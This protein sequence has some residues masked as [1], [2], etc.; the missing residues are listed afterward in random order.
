[1]RNLF[2]AASKLLGVYFVFLGLRHLVA[3]FMLRDGPPSP[4]LGYLLFA[5]L[6]CVFGFVLAFRTDWLGRVL[7]VS[8][9]EAAPVGGPG[10]EDVLRTGIV[11]IGLYVFVTRVGS[12]LTVVSS[13][14]TGVQFGGFGAIAG[15]ILI[16]CVPLALAIFFVVRADRVVGWIDRR[17][18]PV[19]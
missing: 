7:R 1:M 16:E 3:A 13:H 2:F 10:T 12:V 4:A 6:A 19:A 18:A 11:L 9:E 8:P 17:K 5:A 14:L 15:R